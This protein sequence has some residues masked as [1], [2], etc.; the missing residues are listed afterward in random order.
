MI[1]ILRGSSA[2]PPPGE[3]VVLVRRTPSGARLWDFFCVSDTGVEPLH[4]GWYADDRGGGLAVWGGGRY[5]EVR[6]TP[7]DVL[8][9]PLGEGGE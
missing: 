1:F 4:D 7:F 8:P 2:T 9:L 5:W 3:R 6:S